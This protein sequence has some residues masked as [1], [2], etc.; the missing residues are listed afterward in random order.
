[1]LS[2]GILVGGSMFI[3]SFWVVK[4]APVGF[5]NA[6]GHF[7]GELVGTELTQTNAECVLSR[8]NQYALSEMTTALAEQKGDL[9]RE[10]QIRDRLRAEVEVEL[11]DTLA[12]E[13]AK[14]EAEQAEAEAKAAAALAEAEAKLQQEKE[15][16]AVKK[17][18]KK[19]KELARQKE[20]ESAVQAA[21][22]I[23]AKQQAVAKPVVKIPVTPSPVTATEAKPVEEEVTSNTPCC[24]CN[25][26]DSSAAP[27]P[28]VLRQ[29]RD[30]NGVETSVI[31][32]PGS[33][34]HAMAWELFTDAERNKHPQYQTQT[35]PV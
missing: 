8:V 30:D 22:D 17:Q 35:Q 27:Y 10:E 12:E 25:D 7:Y 4:I 19:A 20:V 33:T 23:Q 5:N 9:D 6:K 1:M 3:A 28:K 26:E 14:E 2:L 34:C 21:L 31:H 29:F 16:A 11:R 18:K 32:G 15:L 24:M 13:K